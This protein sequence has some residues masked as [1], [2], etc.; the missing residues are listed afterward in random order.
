MANKS[1]QA[2]GLRSL[3]NGARKVARSTSDA[4][5]HK[6]IQSRVHRDHRIVATRLGGDWIGTVY[7]PGS[8]AIVGSVEGVSAQEVVVRGIEKINELLPTSR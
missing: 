8:N 3:A 1:I 6:R 4:A 7:A 2:E 5:D